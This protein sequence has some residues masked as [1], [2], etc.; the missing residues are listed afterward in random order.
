MG[1]I[2]RTATAIVVKSNPY[3]KLSVKHVN[4]NS[5]PT[6]EKKTIFVCNHQSNMDPFALICGALP[7]E[8]KWVSKSD[9]FAIPFAGRMMSNAGDVPIVFK[10]KKMD[11]MSTDRDSVKSA[12]NKLKEHLRNDNAV[13]FFP[14]GR[15]SSTP[16]QLLE[17]KKG[18]S[19]MS[20]ETGADIVPIGLYGTFTMWGIEEALPTPGKAAIVVGEPISVQG[21]T[22][23]K[24]VE[25]LNEKT[26]EA[27]AELLQK[28]MAEYAKM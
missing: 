25:T 14:E 16:D 19:I 4:K 2:F 17:W 26:R 7:I 8:T 20:L 27:V 9:L 21:M 13:F 22:L 24:D 15:R 3:W 18:A 28:A 11:D 23:E 1:K 5:L 10:S 6:Q 12:M